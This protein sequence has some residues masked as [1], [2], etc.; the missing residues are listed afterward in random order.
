MMILEVG[1]T[2]KMKKKHPCG[3]DTWILIK[4]G[5]ECKIKCQGCDR[6][7]ILPRRDLIKRM[8]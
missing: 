8:K 5:I 4:T 7:I 6:E 2:I 1:Q 3:S